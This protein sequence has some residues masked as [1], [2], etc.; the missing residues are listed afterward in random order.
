MP[1]LTQLINS[2]FSASLKYHRSRWNHSPV[3][4]SRIVPGLQSGRSIAVDSLNQ[5]NSC[6]YKHIKAL[7]QAAAEPAR[8]VA[9]LKAACGGSAL[10]SR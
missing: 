5:L 1:R 2:G 4:P 8:M 6:V 10:F 7:A 9:V 3:L